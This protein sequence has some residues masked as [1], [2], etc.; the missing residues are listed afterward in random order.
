M[1]IGVAGQLVPGIVERPHRIR[2]LPRGFADHEERR[3][4]FPQ[5]IHVGRDEF[6][7]GSP[8]ERTPGRIHIEFLDVH[9]EQKDRLHFAGAPGNGR[10]E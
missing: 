7:Q 4:L 5:P 10:N 2:K 8:P 3:L 9:A 1:Q 6:W